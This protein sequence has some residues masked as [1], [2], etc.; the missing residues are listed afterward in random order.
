MRKRC[1]RGD[2]EAG[3]NSQDG[4]E[5]HRRDEAQ[6]QRAAE[7]ERQ[8]RC[9]R[10]DSARGTLDGVSADQC[11][12]T[13]AQ[14]QG[15]Q[16]EQADQPDGPDHGLAGFLGGGNRVEAHQHVGQGRCAEDQRQAQGHKVQL[17]G[18][19]LAV[20]QARVEHVRVA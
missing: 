4:G 5:S 15:E 12:G 1:R 9:G 7:V 13:V 18:F 14:D 17:G 20:L 19:G 16:V 6:Q 2:G 11:R 10:V 3:D 8:Q